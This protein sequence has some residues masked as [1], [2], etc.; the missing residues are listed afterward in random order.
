MASE[1]FTSESSGLGG[2]RGHRPPPRSVEV[3]AVQRL[4]PRIVSVLF[5]G[6]ALSGF[7]Q[8][9][10]T[11]H[12]K[13]LLPDANGE[14]AMPTP[15]PAGLS[16]PN[17]R[18]IMRTYTPRRYDTAANTLEVQFVLHGEGPAARFAQNATAGDRAAIGGPGG[19]F[20]VDPTVSTWWIGGDESALPAIATLI[21]AL[22][23]R[24]SA[25]VHLEVEGSGHH[26]A[27]PTHP[28]V[29]IRWHDRTGGGTDRWGSELLAVVGRSQIDRHTHVWVGCEAS[30]VRRIRSHLLNERTLKSTQVTTRGYWRLGETNHPDHDFG[31][32]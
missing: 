24:A 28:G 8:P 25:E 15:G 7:P 11:A 20:S 14:V 5:G 31:E 2:R 10:P 6:Q 23:A 30:A 4:A 18:P 27:M 13:V 29:E 17:G 21:E 26:I 22:P 9:L 19:R 16:W 1:P 3:V 12:I 32:D